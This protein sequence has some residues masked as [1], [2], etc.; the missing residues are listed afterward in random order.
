M[1]TLLIEDNVELGD[2]LKAHLL[3]SGH[4]CIW[5]EST[6]DFDKTIDKEAFDVIVLDL[7]LPRVSGSQLLNSMRE[8]RIAMPVL[9]ITAR[10][11]ID[12]RV[13]H[14]DAGADDYLVKPFELEEF[15]SRLNAVARR[16]VG[17]NQPLVRRGGLA[18]DPLAR[19]V[20]IDGSE[21]EYVRRE[22]QI[23][24]QLAHAREQTVMRSALVRNVFGYENDI[25]E[26]ALEI[27]ISRIRR[28]FPDGTDVAIITERGVGY[29]LTTGNDQ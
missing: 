8:R 1:K 20:F 12:Q 26:N 22:F 27:Y 21:V 23:L 28:K 18:I 19:R 2:A 11:E 4:H 16:G 5:L 9:I 24:L 29:R 15:S 10:S 25:S 14:L 13:R 3:R 17:L 6:A 7:M